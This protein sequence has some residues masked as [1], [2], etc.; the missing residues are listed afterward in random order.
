MQ[1]NDIVIERPSDLTAEWL[2][3]AI[4]APVTGFT[5][6]RIG[7]GQM[8]ECYRIGLTYGAGAGRSWLGGPQGGRHRSD[9]QAD[10]RSRWGSTSGR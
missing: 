3:A 2:A 1:T 10:R 6:D 8:S 4:G 9:E 7:T 5:V